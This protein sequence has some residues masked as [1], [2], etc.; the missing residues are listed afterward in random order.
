M[1]DSALKAIL[2]C[3]TRYRQELLL[4]F[5]VPDELTA[6]WLKGTKTPIHHA[7]TA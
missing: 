4:P 6:D 7:A 1:Q 5:W 2:D 3:G